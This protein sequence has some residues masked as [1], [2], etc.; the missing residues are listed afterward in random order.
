MPSAKLSLTLAAASMIL[1]IAPAEATPR[2]Y[3]LICKGGGAMVATIKSNA[4]ISLRFSPGGEAG[5]VQAGSAPGLTAA[6]A[7]ESPTY[8]HWRGTA[9][10]P[11]TSW[12]AC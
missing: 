4:T 10:V 6:S 3:Q 7:R 11:P 12:T 8:C 1:A 5:V 2:S 9:R